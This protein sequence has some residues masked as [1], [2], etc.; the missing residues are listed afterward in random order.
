MPTARR[1]RA[2]LRALRRARAEL[3]AADVL[4][5]LARSLADV[6]TSFEAA[7]RIAEAITSV[8]GCDRSC[9]LLPDDNGHLVARGLAGHSTEPD[10]VLEGFVLGTEMLD[11]PLETMPSTVMLWA[12]TAPPK[13]SE[14]VTHFGS[15]PWRS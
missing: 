2:R 1:T 5:G 6:T 8:T 10:S 11:V 12:D 13:A 14:A 3:A 9:V 15:G 4:L 7:Q